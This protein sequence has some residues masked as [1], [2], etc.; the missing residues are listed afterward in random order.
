MRATAE[1]IDITSQLQSD[2]INRSLAGVKSYKNDGMS[3][4][5]RTDRLTEAGVLRTRTFFRGRE[6]NPDNRELAGFMEYMRQSDKRMSDMILFLADIK[7]KERKYTDLT[8]E[9][10]QRLI[11]AINKIK[12]LTALMPKNIPYPI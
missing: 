9:E 8:K 5:E 7:D 6:D 2:D 11:I 3:F 4:S 10:K 12:S 1:L